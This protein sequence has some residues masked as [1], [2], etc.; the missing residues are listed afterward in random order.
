MR[1]ARLSA[2]SLVLDPHNDRLRLFG[3][4]PADL[5][6]TDGCLCTCGLA[7]KIVALAWPGDDLEWEAC[8]FRKEGVLH[9]FFPGRGDASLWA[10]YT[11]PSRRREVEALHHAL[12]LRSAMGRVECGSAP[13][14][15]GYRCQLGSPSHAPEIAALMR[16]C[17]SLYPT[18]IREDGFTQQIAAKKSRWRIVR[19]RMGAIVAVACAELDLSSCSAEL[20]HFATRSDQRGRG[21]M[22]SLVQQLVCELRGSFRIYAFA[23]AGEPGINCVLRRAGFR[24]SGRMINDCKMPRGWESMNVWGYV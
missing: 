4:T 16:E 17:F 24:Y 13:L 20:T 12:V 1:Y 3:V 7:S 9:Q 11:N 2:H 23:R 14:P 8:G 22:R 19:N 6:G 18:P 21:L 15:R 10:A 5:E